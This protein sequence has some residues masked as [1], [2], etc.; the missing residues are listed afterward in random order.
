MKYINKDRITYCTLLCVVVLLSSCVNTLELVAPRG[1]RRVMSHEVAVADAKAYFDTHFGQNTRSNDQTP[2]EEAPYVVGNLVPDWESGVTMADNE[3]AYTDFAIQ[4][5]YRFFLA[6]EDE[7][8]RICGLEL[9]SRLASVVDFDL[10]GMN[11]YVATYIPDI[12]F[13][14]CYDYFVEE[15]LLTCEHIDWF[16]GVVLYTNLWGYHV[17]A[18]KY[19]DGVLVDSSFLND[20]A[21]TE[22][23]NIAD[24]MRVMKGIALFV[25]PA[26][27]GTRAIVAEDISG[28]QIIYYYNDS[29]ELVWSY[30]QIDG[31]VATRPILKP[32]SIPGEDIVD[33]RTIKNDTIAPIVPSGGGGG[34]GST[35]TE[36]EEPTGEEI[37]EDLFDTSNLE[38][39]E[40]AAVADML[41]EIYADCMGKALLDS[42]IANESNIQYATSYPDNYDIPEELI[43]TSAYIYDQDMLVYRGEGVDVLLHELFHTYQYRMINSEETFEASN[44]K[45]EIEAQIARTLFAV[46]L[47][48]KGEQSYYNALNETRLGFA[49]VY[50]TNHYISHTAELQSS[51]NSKYTKLYDYIGT[52]LSDHLGYNYVSGD[53]S[54]DYELLTAISENCDDYGKD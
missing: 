34:S 6:L 22:E 29:G 32:I 52:Y 36:R 30:C 45:L 27:E 40:K 18:Y 39:P 10:E 17:A 7:E 21:Q 3:R 26:A 42:L 48:D 31:I 4:K 13:L 5:D 14:S 16:T 38:E 46:R 9:Y 28:G 24:F 53:V 12:S 47:K 8:Q 54:Y 41:E 35:S 20:T 1:E 15:G 51:V 49:F 19:Y 25:A 2:T 44:A 23:E 11:Q 43:N 37:A 50:L 33:V